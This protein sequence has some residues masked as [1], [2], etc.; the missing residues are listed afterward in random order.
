[1]SKK[2]LVFS[3]VKKNTFIFGMLEEAKKDKAY[4]ESN[5]EF[6]KPKTSPK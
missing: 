6:L 3:A 1:M 2:K 4:K 5:L